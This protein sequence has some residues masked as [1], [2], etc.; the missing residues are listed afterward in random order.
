MLQLTKFYEQCFQNFNHYDYEDILKSTEALFLSINQQRSTKA[1][2]NLFYAL[3]Q[4]LWT[5][6]RES[7]DDPHFDIQIKKK[8]IQGLHL[9][10]LIFGTYDK[11]IFILKPLVE[12]INQSENRPAKILEIGSGLGKLTMA[13]GQKISAASMQVELTGSDIVQDFVNEA[14]NE[15]HTKGLKI[16]FKVID[17]CQ[18]EQI[19]NQ[20]YDII[21]NLHGMHHF[22]PM[23]LSTVMSGS[24]KVATKAFIGIDGYRGIGNLLFM[25]L[26]GMGAS[27]LNGHKSFFRDSLISGRKLYTS[28]QLEILA[29]LGCPKDEVFAQNLTPGLTVI[30]ILKH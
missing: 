2:K 17:A 15:A 26:A 10:N 21:F 6:A 9:K 25:C 12:E 11:A 1:R 5:N 8:I 4:A 24:M 19:E 13:M 22:T 29:R 18:L 20:S 16:D 27:L 3:D 7:I 23:Q 28:K 30:K 14:N